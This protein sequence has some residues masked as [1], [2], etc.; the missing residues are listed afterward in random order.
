MITK[1]YEPGDPAEEPGLTLRYD[2]NGPGPFEVGFSG[3]SYFNTQ[4]EAEQAMQEYAIA[5]ADNVHGA[6][7][8]ALRSLVEAACEKLGCGGASLLHAIELLSPS[9]AVPAGWTDD[10]HAPIP[11]ADYRVVQPVART[12]EESVWRTEVIIPSDDGP[13]AERL[14]LYQDDQGDWFVGTIRKGERVCMHGTRFCG[15]GGGPRS[16]LNSAVV[17][18]LAASE[19]GDADAIAS[20]LSAVTQEYHAEHRR[21]SDQAAAAQPTVPDRLAFLQSQEATLLDMIA[22][23]P[24]V[25]A[26]NRLSLRARLEEVREE[27]ATEV[28][29][30]SLFAWTRDPHSEEGYF[31]VASIDDAKADALG[32]LGEYCD[33]DP[34][35]DIIVRPCEIAFPPA[36]MFSADRMIEDLTE[37]CSDVADWS[38]FGGQEEPAITA[39]YDATH[40]LDA[41]LADT[42]QRWAILHGV[43]LKGDQRAVEI[44]AWRF[45]GPPRRFVYDEGTKTWSEKEVEDEG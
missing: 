22:R 39:T 27:L 24:S 38:D 28:S 18:L 37:D 25:P 21:S 8:K 14:A 42:F 31:V 44:D 33:P 17:R 29:A 6:E 34:I 11:A 26:I 41:M 9:I 36:A 5:I 40:A 7:L 3:E 16:R 30:R 2:S 20:R 32:R 45:T 10:A 13:D 43:H 15:G 35:H 12:P 23:T 1:H 4:P 19:I